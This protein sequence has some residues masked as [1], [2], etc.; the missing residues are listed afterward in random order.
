LRQNRF[1]KVAGSVLDQATWL[2][3]ESRKTIE[4]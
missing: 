3:I 2:P 4:H 1:G